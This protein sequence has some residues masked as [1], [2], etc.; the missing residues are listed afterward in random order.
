MTMLRMRVGPA[1]MGRLPH[2]CDLLAE[3][4]NIC[5]EHNIYHAQISAIGALS[6]WRV[7]YYDQRAHEYEFLT[8]NDH[9]EIVS[10]LGNASLYEGAP[11]VHAH[12]GLAN[13]EGHVL[14]G[15][16]AE[17]CKV[18]ACEYIIQKFFTEIPLQRAPDP[19]TGL[20]LWVKP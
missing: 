2:N 18:F 9:R 3:L 10:L 12:L 14:G 5:R 6:Q 13:A 1:Y 15:H 17:G 20:N 4:T 8:G 11:M 19:E 16:L 7:G